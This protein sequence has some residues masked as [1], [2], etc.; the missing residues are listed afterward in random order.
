MDLLHQH[1]KYN[2]NDFRSLNLCFC[3]TKCPHCP[4][5]ST[6]ETPAVICHYCN[7][8]PLC[9]ICRDTCADGGYHGDMKMDDVA[10]VNGDMKVDDNRFIY[11]KRSSRSYV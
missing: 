2:Y 1:Y 9:H 3:T 10:M 5:V 4:L 8:C 11:V 6:T 7:H